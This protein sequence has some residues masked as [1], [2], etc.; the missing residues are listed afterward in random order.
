M[1]TPTHRL[2]AP[3]ALLLALLARPSA[4]QVA[5]T[6]TLAFPVVADTYVESTL[7]TSNFDTDARLRADADPIRISYLRFTVSGLGGRPVQQARVRV[8]V[9]GPST[10]GGTIHAISDRTWSPAAIT[11]STRPAVDGPGIATLGAVALGSVVE[12]DVTAAVTGEGAYDFAIDSTSTDGVSYNSSTALSGL[13]PQLVVTVPA[14]ANPVVSILQ[15]AD[16]AVFFVGDMVTLQAV[17]TDDADPDLAAGLVWSSTLQPALGTGALVSV[18]LVE[19]THTVTAAVTDSSGLGGSAH[20]DLTVRPRPAA[21]TPPLIAITAPRDQAVFAAGQAIIFAGT[22]TDLED[23]TLTGSLQWTSTIDGTIGRGATFTRTL[24]AGTHRI[25]ARVTDSGGQ[26]DSQAITVTVTLPPA[27]SFTASADTYVMSSKA[28]RKF[29]TTAKLLAGASP[30]RIIYLRFGVTGASPFSVTR[31]VLRLSVG[32]GISDGSVAA[33][34]VYAITNNTWSEATT[35]YRNRPPIDGPA[36]A[37][38]GAA[39]PDQVVEYDVT[40]AVRRDGTVNFALASSAADGISFRSRESSTGRPQLILTLGPPNIVLSGTFSS[41]YIHDTLYPDSRIDARAATFLASST[42]YYPITLGGGPGVL[43][44]GGAVLGQFD[45]SYGW[46]QMHDLNNAAIVFENSS[47]T[48]DGLRADNVTDGIRPQQGDNFT[49]RNVHLS[50][51]RDDCVEN[52][53]LLG[54]LV[55]DALFDGC[56][57]A[58]SARPSQPIIDSGYNGAAKLW[59]IQNT[60]VRLQPMPGPNVATGDGLGHGG[61][62]KWHRWDDPATSLSP[63][64]ALYNN[65]FLVERVGDVGPDRMGVPPGQVLGCSNNVVVWL[66]P[67]SY[68]SALPPCFTVTTNRA[69]WDNAVAARIARHPGVRP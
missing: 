11:Y 42:N 12:F 24:S 4:A 9:S 38:A 66:G 47:F 59:T 29:G 49:V 51:V 31:A 28:T 33:G 19:G 45:R 34:T 14:A 15:P 6:E 65:I 57:N 26:A 55:D 37:S 39:V 41:R 43:F 17:V 8:G 60:F 3:A 18:P 22:A 64:L 63:K 35:Y 54:G 68:P 2:L 69:V 44:G 21:N 5:A 53:H 10:K 30:E 67:G 25:V 46:V 56:Y 50:Y 13:R 32:S 7:P 62:F 48:V 40:A 16:G 1:H 52:D 20:I 27:L 23:G 36:L 61:F 58:F